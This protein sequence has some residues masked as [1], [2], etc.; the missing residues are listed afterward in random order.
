MI[1]FKLQERISDKEFAEG[2]SVTLKE[3][4]EATGIHRVTL[5][6]LA[7]HKLPN[8]GTEILDKLCDYFDCEIGGLAE[9]I[10]SQSE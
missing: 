3:I 8:V 2:R 5:S 7:S 9:H 10:K 6:K 1:R 4:A